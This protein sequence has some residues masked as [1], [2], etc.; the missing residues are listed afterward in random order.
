MSRDPNGS[1][2]T[3][4][5][6]LDGIKQ[7]I[8]YAISDHNQEIARTTE[9]LL[10]ASLASLT[11]EWLASCMA[12]AIERAVRNGIQ[13]TLPK[14]VEEAVQVYFSHGE[15]SQLVIEAIRRRFAL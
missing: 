6:E 12:T 13:A 14:I 9:E 2:P 10:R 3:L 11:P 1:F 5:L 8:I 15:G 4:R 7:G